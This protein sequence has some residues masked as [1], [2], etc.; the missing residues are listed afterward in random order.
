MYVRAHVCRL[1]I[2]CPRNSLL[3]KFTDASN[4]VCIHIQVVNAHSGGGY[5]VSAIVFESK[6][7][8][9]IELQFPVDEDKVC[10]RWQEDRRFAYGDHIEVIVHRLHNRLWA[11]TF[12]RG[13]VPAI[14]LVK[15]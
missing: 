5:D 10:L 9:V 11:Q 2:V 14:V 7:D 4:A 15:R 8:V 13:C 12:Q 3:Q 1:N 6:I